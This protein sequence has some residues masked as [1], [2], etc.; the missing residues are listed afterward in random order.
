VQK[1]S[2]G[3]QWPLVKQNDEFEHRIFASMELP[4]NM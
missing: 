3:E 1:T 4:K 2:P